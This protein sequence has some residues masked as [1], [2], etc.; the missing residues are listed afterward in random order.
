LGLSLILPKSEYLNYREAPEKG[1]GI[2]TSYNA[3]LKVD[4]EKPIRYYVLAGWEISD[5]ILLNELISNVL[6]KPKSIR[7]NIL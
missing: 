7:L 6:Q 5:K 2:T 3:L 1:Q 4:N